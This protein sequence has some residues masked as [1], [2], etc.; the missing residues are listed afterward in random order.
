M[1]DDYKLKS[2]HCKRC[3]ETESPS[4][5]F[6]ARYALP[7]NLSSEYTREEDLEKENKYLQGYASGA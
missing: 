3:D 2:I 1:D 5:N 4:M 7:V 6:C